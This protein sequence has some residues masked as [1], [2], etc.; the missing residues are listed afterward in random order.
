MLD[1]SGQAISFEVSPKPYET[2]HLTI[3]NQRKV[4][5]LPM[6]YDR[7]GAEEEEMDGVF[8]TSLR[9]PY[10]SNGNPHLVGVI[11]PALVSAECSTGNQGAPQR[12]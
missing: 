5:P 7:I 1:A 2:E 6:D 10:P 4:N 11:H 9:A 3:P 12:A 8:Q